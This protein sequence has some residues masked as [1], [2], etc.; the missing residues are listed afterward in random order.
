MYAP[1]TGQGLYGADSAPSAYGVAVPSN[2]IP[3]PGAASVNGDPGAGA[4]VSV[5]VDFWRSSGFGLI[6][7]V[8][9]VVYFDL[10]LLNR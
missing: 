7:L 2:V 8:A 1:V 3:M 10:R 6:L 5:P 9:L 4:T